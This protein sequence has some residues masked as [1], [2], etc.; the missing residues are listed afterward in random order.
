MTNKEFEAYAGYV[1]VH[2]GIQL[3]QEKKTLLE[4]RLYRMISE[5]HSEEFQDAQGFYEYLTRNKDGRAREMLANAITTNHTFFMRE[6]DHFKY[7]ADTVLPWWTQQLHNGDLR[8]WCAAC[9]TG[10]EAYTLAMIHQEF[11]SLK[12]G[13]WDTTLLATD[14]SQAALALAKEG[15]YDEA[16][17][18]SLPKG[19][20]CNFQK[21]EAS[22]GMRV[23]DRIRSKV[24]FRRFNLMSE[25]FPFRRH[26]HTIFC[27]NVMIYF[28]QP[29]R[30]TLLKKFYDLLEPGGY[31]FVGHSEV[32][33]RQVVPF[34][35]VMPSVY[36][37]M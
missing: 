7:Y 37:R 19:W 28:D 11:F 30:N 26:F 27:R 15:V 5:L 8:T 23:V 20:Q 3:P 35:Y 31:L 32:A 29:T 6:A 24:I 13:S 34:S 33:D 10:E 2:F 14:L 4:T 18:R 16:A 17:V 25:V 1:R 36:R 21:N 12:A 9:S 22:C